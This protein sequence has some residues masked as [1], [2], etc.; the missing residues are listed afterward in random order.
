MKKTLAFLYIIF[1]I[2][3]II[4]SVLALV[5]AFDQF[6]QIQTAGIDTN[7]GYLFGSILFPLL[8]TVTGRWLYRKGKENWKANT[9]AK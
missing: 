7:Y 9:Q 4:I 3:L 1:G 2:I 8:I 6:Q 5:K